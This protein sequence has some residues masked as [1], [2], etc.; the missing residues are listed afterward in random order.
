MT[1]EKHSSK[2][3]AEYIKERLTRFFVPPDRYWQELPAR[4]NTAV[5]RSLKGLCSPLLLLNL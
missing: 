3:S 2:G 4:T 1:A 5:Q